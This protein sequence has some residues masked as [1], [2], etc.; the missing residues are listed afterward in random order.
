MITLRFL[1]LR[2][3]VDLLL[4]W[5]TV[6]KNIDTVNDNSEAGRITD[7]LVRSKGMRERGGGDKVKKSLIAQ[8]LPDDA[9]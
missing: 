2:S 5:V 8:L 9:E 7:T 1:G 4:W 3:R 6:T